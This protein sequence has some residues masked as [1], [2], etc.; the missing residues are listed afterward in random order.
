MKN[1][2]GNLIHTHKLALAILTIVLVLGM[3]SFA[4]A[5]QNP[6]STPP[7]KDNDTTRGELRNFDRFLDSHP[8]IAKDLKGNPNLVNDA[9]YLSQHPEL[10]EFLNNHPG[11]REEIKENPKGFMNRE[12]RFER[13]GGDVTRGELKNFDGFLDKHPEIDEQLRKNPGLI[14]D[15]KYVNDH[16][17]LKEFLENHPGVREE[18]KEHPKYIMHRE[19]QF[20][21]RERAAGRRRK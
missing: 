15:P 11:V 1:K 20:E 12:A 19:K 7:A 16:P 4:G 21:R 18:L 10:K 6:P 3:A 5:Q 8:A 2:A 17:E 14:N 9:N 13:S